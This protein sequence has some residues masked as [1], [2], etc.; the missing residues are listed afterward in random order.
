MMNGYGFDMGWSGGLWMVVF[1]I[2]IILLAIWILRL[3]FPA[4]TTQPPTPTRAPEE[5]AR[6][7]YARGEI[8]R[9]DYLALVEDLKDQKE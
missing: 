3:I 8:S 5:I 4:T 6:A 2:A 1:W 9:E 7:R